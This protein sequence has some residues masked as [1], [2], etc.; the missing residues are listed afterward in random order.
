MEKCVTKKVTDN[1]GPNIP[2][3]TV[4]ELHV[5]KAFAKVTFVFFVYISFENL[6]FSKY[7]YSF[8]SLKSY[9]IKLV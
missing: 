9:K 8:Y 3:Q 5:T 1:N 4:N 6:L 7:R 2:I